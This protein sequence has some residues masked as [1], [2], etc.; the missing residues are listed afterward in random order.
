M[1]MLRLYPNLLY[2]NKFSLYIIGAMCF[3]YC[4]IQSSD[5]GTSTVELGSQPIL[6]LNATYHLFSP[7]LR[8][9]TAYICEQTLES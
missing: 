2:Y 4:L 5:Y 3:G 6:Y 7:C 1:K 9:E 8:V